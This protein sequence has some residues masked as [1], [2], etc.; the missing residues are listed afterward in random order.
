MS[1][2]RE[3]ANELEQPDDRPAADPTADEEM[4]ARELLAVAREDRWH[5]RRKIRSNPLQHRVYR[6][7]VAIA[8]L[9][10]I[11]L[12]LVTGPIPGPG[13]I[14]LILLGLAIWASEFE[15]AH[16]LMQLFKAGLHRFRGWTRRRQAAFWV[17]FIGCCGVCGYV[18]LLL[19]GVPAWVPANADA[20]L[21][22][23]PG[24]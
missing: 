4:P 18:S 1:G 13:G 7:V 14:P 15:R 6:V 5:W 23:L 21:Q 8:G 22:Q 17:V 11:G 19:M 9:M 20:L 3:T 10:L 24:L 16:R 12:G 2:R